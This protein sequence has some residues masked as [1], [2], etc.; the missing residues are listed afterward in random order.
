MAHRADPPGQGGVHVI[1]EHSPSRRAQV[2][3]QT[4][5]QVF[6]AA[7]DAE[8]SAEEYLVDDGW[9]VVDVEP[10]TVEVNGNGSHDPIGIGPTVELVLGNGHVPTDRIGNGHA[11]VLVNG[12]G[13]S[14]EIPEP[15][16]T[17]FS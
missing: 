11:A 1:P 7:R 6:A 10:E 8:A 3:G 14:D 9:K 4:V 16:R 2:G 17:L 12:N 13:H 15:Q 5:E